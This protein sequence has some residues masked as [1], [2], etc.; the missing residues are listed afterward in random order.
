[1]YLKI[2]SSKSEQK[3]FLLLDF[4]LLTNFVMI[5]P[6][7]LAEG[8]RINGILVDLLMIPVFL[9]LYKK[10]SFKINL[11]G[12]FLIG[13]MIIFSSI[14]VLTSHLDGVSISGTV[15]ML[16]WMV[17]FVLGC[18]IANYYIKIRSDFK[19]IKVDYFIYALLGLNAFLILMYFIN[20]F[21]LFFY[22][23]AAGGRLRGL[24]GDPNF[25]AISEW[26]FFMLV[27]L[28]AN[29]SLTK[30]LTI[31]SIIV[32][33][34][35]SGS[36]GTAIAVLI[37][38]LFFFKTIFTQIKIRMNV[39]NVVLFI[40]AAVFVFIF[41]YKTNFQIPGFERIGAVFNSVLSNKFRLSMKE[42]D[43]FLHGRLQIWQASL[44]CFIAYPFGI[45]KDNITIWNFIH[46]GSPAVVHNTYLEILTSSGLMGLM[47]F[48]FL[49]IYSFARSIKKGWKIWAMWVVV[50][51]LAAS[52]FYSLDNFRLFWFALGIL[53]FNTGRIKNRVVDTVG[54]KGANSI[55]V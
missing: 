52:L 19:R 2:E 24:F 12:F 3:E 20:P 7:V 49:L 29:K 22:A 26:S 48:F 37:A 41:L 43:Y 50:F 42:L 31:F 15:K 6:I 47:A 33:H 5:F 17:Y 18:S 13:S 16:S 36:R 14:G 35:M 8:Y 46:I 1:M 28:Y 39:K 40:F 27:L 30:A 53:C 51:I 21:A 54:R 25:F 34:I 55:A 10:H 11:T 9:Y 32:V 4:I 23:N 45:G 38:P 44:K